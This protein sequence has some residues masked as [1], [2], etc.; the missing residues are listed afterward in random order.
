MRYYEIYAWTE[1]PWCKDAKDLL[2][3]NGEQFMFCCLDQS[4]SLLDFLKNKYNWSTVPMIIE[5]YTD[6][7]GE[8]FIGGF[9]DLKKYLEEE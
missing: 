5:K 3:K 1:C 9:S 8:K 4:D 6:S 2:I 7:D